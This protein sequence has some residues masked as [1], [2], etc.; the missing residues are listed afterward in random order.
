MVSRVRWIIGAVA[1]VLLV[2]ILVNMPPLT[3]CMSNPAASDGQYWFPATRVVAEPW[4]GKHH[5]YGIFTIPE[6]YK[7]DH[8]YTATLTIQ[9]IDAEFQA[10]SPEDE[11]AQGAQVETG[12][13]N[14]RVYLSTRTAL[15]FLV[16]GRF[17]NVRTSCHWWLSITEKSKFSESEMP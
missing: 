14:K 7:F 4:R 8:L 13:Y 10:G 3:P 16:T 17:G 2:V 11:D 9:G 6:R 12:F 5:V 15:W 1:P